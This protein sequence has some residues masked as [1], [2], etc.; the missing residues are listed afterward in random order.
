MKVEI[1][2]FIIIIAFIIYYYGIKN[3]EKDKSN[4][5]ESNNLSNDI[6]LYNRLRDYINYAINQYSLTIDKYMILAVIKKESY[7]D[8]LTKKNENVTGDKG[9]SIGYMQVSSIALKDVNNYYKTSFTDSLL[10]DEKFNIVI[11]CLYLNMCYLSAMREKAKNPIKL[12]FK[13]YNG[14]ID[15]T[16]TSINAIADLYSEQAYKYYIDLKKVL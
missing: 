3:T 7:Y 6:K 9:K 1:I 16:E 4:N 12:A 13:K 10:Y 2:I 5:S 15:E 8:A 14:G 11:G